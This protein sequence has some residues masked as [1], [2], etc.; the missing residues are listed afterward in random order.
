ML[1]ISRGDGKGSVKFSFH[2]IKIWLYAECNFLFHTVAS[3]ERRWARFLKVW[4]I[5]NSCAL[6]KFSFCLLFNNHFQSFLEI[7]CFSV[8]VGTYVLK[9]CS[10]DWTKSRLKRLKRTAR[11]YSVSMVWE[12]K[13]FLSNEVRQTP[14]SEGN[15]EISKKYWP[16]TF[17]WWLEISKSAL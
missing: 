5:E 6:V 8:S 14:F 17:V 13:I 10:L 11:V 7:V 2:K 16:T 1:C 12:K 9:I 3:S 4:S 15:S